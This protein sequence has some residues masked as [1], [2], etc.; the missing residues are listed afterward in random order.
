[1]KLKMKLNVS[2]SE[3]YNFLLENLKRELNVKKIEKGMKFKKELSSKFSQKVESSV[4]LINI[5]ENKE[6]SLVYKTSLGENIVKYLLNDIDNENLEVEYIEEYY[7]DSFWNKYN[8]MIVE[9]LMSYFLKKKKKRV[10]KQIEEYIK[11]NRKL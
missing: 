4:E 3:F 2:S 6:Y 5:E 10:L 1:M 7:T 9:F 8:N 11:N